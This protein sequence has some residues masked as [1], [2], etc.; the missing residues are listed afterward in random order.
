MKN[1]INPWEVFDEIECSHNPEYIV[2]VS[3]LRHYTNIFGIDKRLLDFLG[4]EKNTILDIETFCFGGM[5]IFGIKEDC[6]SV[7]EDCK[8]QREAKEE[9][10][11][12]NRKLIAMLK[13]KRENMCGI[14]TRKVKLMLNKKIKQ[15]DF[16]AKIYRV[17]LE[18]QDYNIK[19]KDAPFPYSEKMYAKKE[20]LIDK[21]IEIYNESK[22][23]FGY[24]EDK[25]QRVS[26]IVY[27]DLPLGNQISFY[28]TVKR[29]IPAYEKEWDG[30][31]N[32]TLDKLEKEIKQYLNGINEQTN[33][34]TKI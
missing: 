23:S 18:I 24:S 33:I 1:N 19:A 12:K 30:L 2:C 28:S 27:F 29:N 32:S 15:G 3:H 21:L 5:D 20:D 9:A 34:I 6:T 22:L 16:T 10:L 14:G 11:E 4:M 8:R 7:I 17:A 25:G 13:L 26:F 31:V